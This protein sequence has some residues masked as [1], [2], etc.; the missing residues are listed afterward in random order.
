MNLIL[1][2]SGTGNSLAAARQIGRTLGDT[3]VLSMVRNPAP[4]GEYERVGFVFPCY[5]GALPRFVESYLEKLEIGALHT[6]Y[7][8]AVE[9]YGGS[10]SAAAGMVDKILRAKAAKLNY[11]A[12]VRMFANYI[13]LY[14]MQDGA[15]EK[16][17]RAATALK[18]VARAVEKKEQT[19]K[20]SLNPAALFYHKQAMKMLLKKVKDFKVSDDCNGCGLC[21]KLCPVG[22]ITLDEGVPAFGDNCEQCMACIQWCPKL[23]INYKDRTDG[24]PRYHH[25][26][27]TAKDL[28]EN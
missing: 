2:F 14:K 6:E 9:T 25:P 16:A 22:N 3:Y 11:G 20:F 4:A 18:D 23:A 1:Y 13:A 10:P 15:E 7:F 5:A 21:A 27:I 28:L 26:G 19:E 24:A 12:S 17:E 8:F